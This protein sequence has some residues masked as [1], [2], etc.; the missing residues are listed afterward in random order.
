MTAR[1]LA[2]F[3]LLTLILTIALTLTLTLTLSVSVL[4]RISRHGVRVSKNQGVPPFPVPTLPFPP[5][6]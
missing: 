4:S 6:P 3:H 5:F 2:L 1:Y